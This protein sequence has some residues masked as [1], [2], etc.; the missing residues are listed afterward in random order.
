[1]RILII[2]N[3][4]VAKKGEHF[5]TNALNG[6]FIDEL[7]SQSNDLTYFQFSSNSN[8]NISSFNL[9]EHGVHCKVVRYKKNK[10]INYAVAYVRVIKE[11]RKV[12]FV[13]LYYP[14]TFKYVSYLCR[15]LRKPYGLYI[16]GMNGV[17]D[18]VS[19]NIYK[20]AYT[21][22]TVSDYFTNKVNDVVGK[23]LAHTI[24]PMIPYTDQDVIVDRQYAQ[25]DCY[26]ILFLGRVAKD[27]GL[28]ELTDAAEQLHQQ[29]R[30]FVLHIV[31]NGE[32]A[33]ELASIIKTKGLS[34]FIYLDGPVFDDQKKAQL[35][36][37]AD[38]YV[39][40]TY[41]EGFPR[42]LYEAMIFGT[43]IVTTFVGGIPALMKDGKNCK[44]I[45]PKS[46]ESIVEAL[47]FA[48]DNYETMA[49][50]AANATRM[51]SRVV[52]HNKPSHAQ[53]LNQ[54]LTHYEQ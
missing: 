17:D 36:Q 25:K 46:T 49:Q 22:F 6:I 20:H 11:I 40:P 4:S 52:D 33:E 5:F 47:T 8:K 39:L 54:I 30:K 29:G 35:Y 50:Y 1:M 41:H 3:A 16:R 21:I 7:I 23:T 31:G 15:I 26:N 48:M 9:E 38:L 24:R 13:Y 45:E 42:T 12:D 14:N 18:K 10:F 37:N 43:P 32:Y 51:V 53:H 34:D 44:R 19:H 27:K 28:L 2:D